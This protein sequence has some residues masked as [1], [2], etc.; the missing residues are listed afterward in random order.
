MRTRLVF[1]TRISKQ[2]HH[3]RIRIMRGLRLP[4]KDSTQ[5]MWLNALTNADS[6]VNVVK[7]SIW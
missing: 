6:I 5:N 3:S 2:Y 7:V 4:L 1:G